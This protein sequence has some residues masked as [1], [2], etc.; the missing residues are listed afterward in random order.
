ML[1]IPNEQTPTDCHGDYEPRLHSGQSGL[2]HEEQP[3]STVSNEFDKDSSA[4]TMALPPAIGHLTISPT[5]DQFAGE[6]AAME[7]VAT[8]IAPA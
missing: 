8:D 2:S 5:E 7:I 6:E 4:P 1:P 3:P